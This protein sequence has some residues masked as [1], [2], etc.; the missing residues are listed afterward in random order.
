ME[1]P[2]RIAASLALALAILGNTGCQTYT[3]H[4]KATDLWKKGKIPEAAAF[5]AQEAGN[6]KDNKDTIIWRLEQ[7]AALRA[8]GQLTESTA[9]FDQ[10][11]EKMDRYDEKAKVNLANEAGAI[12]SNQASLPYEGRNY[13]RVMLNTYKA[14]NY[15]QLGEFD[16]V[17]PELIRVYQRQQDAVENNKKR[18]EKE[19]Q[20]IAKAMEA[21]KKSQAEGGASQA[22]ANSQQTTNQVAQE[23][24][25]AN[26]EAKAKT[27]AADSVAKAQKD[28]KFTNAL[29]TTYAELNT[30]KAYADYVNPFP[31][32]LDG[33][34]FLNFPTGGGSDLE[35]ARKSF[36]RVLQLSG[37]N[38]YVRADLE[39]AEKALRGEPLPPTTYLIFET[40][41]APW[42]DQIR[43]DIPLFFIGE[44]NMPYAGAAF[45]RI[46]L[47]TNFISSLAVSA[48]GAAEATVSI[49]SMDS[50][51]VQSFKNELPTI[52]TKTLLSTTIKAITAYFIN[53]AS[54]HSGLAGLFTK[55]GTAIYQASV[56]IADTRTWT[57]LPKEF[58]VCRFPTPTNQVVSLS[59]PGGAAM[60]EVHV[61]PNSVN[62]IHVKSINAASRPIVNLINFRPSAQM[63]PVAFNPR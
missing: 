29:N 63:R 20:E 26:A 15:F 11:E 42:R 13:D 48:D 47:D 2:Q 37:E 32:Y 36:E 60:G 43:I 16:K 57:T 56:N 41:C 45:P 25:K 8:A 14:L 40:G 44:G 23:E 52:I 28:E 31:V 6:N 51:V 58:Q 24:A 53:E 4:N 59:A 39:S 17:R 7:G 9:A 54:S 38:K 12:L 21:S 10:A 5:L 22:S 27:A 46:K 1:R 3:S 18:I 61:E 30:L 62:L 50:V 19:E 49:A 34:Y 35:R 33:L 55:I